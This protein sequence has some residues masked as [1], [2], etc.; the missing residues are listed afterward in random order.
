MYNLLPEELI[1]DLF[2]GGGGA[3]LGIELAIGRSPDIA[4]NHDPEAI[5]M[6][7]A[8]HPNTKHY[9]ESIW[10]VDPK[11]A[12]GGRDVG[13]AW[14]SPDCKHFSKAK[15]GK[16]VDKKIRGLAWNVVR[17]AREVRPRLIFVENVEEFSGWGPLLANGKP[18]P[19]R[20]GTTFRRWLSQLRKLGYRIEHRELRA[21]D[22][23]APTTRK[24]LFLVARCDNRPIVWPEPTHGPGRTPYRTAAECIDWG[25]PCPSIFGR[26]RP[27]AHNTLRRTARGI[28]RYVLEAANPFVVR[29]G[30]TGHGDSG[31]L[32]GLDE[33]LSTVTSKNE[34]LLVTPTI[35]P[36]T[37]QGERRS[38]PLD[39]PLP[40]VTGA[41]RGELALA[42]P[43]L[44]ELGHGDH[45]GRERRPVDLH[46]PLGTQHAGGNKYALA[47]PTLIQTG[48]GE[49]PGQAPRCLDLH[50]PLGTVVGDQ[51]HALVAAFLGKQYGGN[52]ST[53]GG[54]SLQ[55]PIDTITS[56]D[57]HSLVTCHLQRDFGK[58]IGSDAGEPLGAITAG[59]GGKSALVATHLVKLRGGLDT[60]ANTAQDLREPVPTI[61]AGGTHLAEVRAFL[62]KYYGTAEGQGLGEPLHTITTQ[63]RFG[64]VTVEGEDYLIS[65][66]GL[67]MLSPRE[68]FLAQGFPLNYQIE[69]R[70]GFKLLSKTAQVRMC[71]NSVCPPV[72]M[73]LVMANVGAKQALGP[74]HYEWHPGLV[75]SGEQMSFLDLSALA[76]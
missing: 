33:P 42:A 3:S 57:H 74:A 50:K 10:D 38:H 28:R 43:V 32:R 2:A 35:L 21:C 26:K 20:K 14:F 31:K 56:V 22:Y 51:K 5:A 69:V 11:E 13:L 17:W 48:Y 36:L 49:R 34:H 1:V 40:T 59:G 41:H 4:I 16:P 9:C 27:L 55:D 54:T 58:S 29:I 67:R 39:E 47:A 75:Q 25:L 6:H 46:E 30:H 7:A 61:T 52:E 45:S 37:H 62:I 63:D 64:L 71:G 19:F 53:T 60:H 66:I 24:R 8:N 12:V 18:C 70:H 15:G 68:L 65:D 44:V 73:A 76:G 72:A 23:G